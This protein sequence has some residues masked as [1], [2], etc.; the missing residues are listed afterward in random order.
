M[1]LAEK[2]GNLQTGAKG[3]TNPSPKKAQKE[4]PWKGA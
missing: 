4:S 1:L 3:C 2:S